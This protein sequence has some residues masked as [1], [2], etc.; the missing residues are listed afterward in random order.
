MNLQWFKGLSPEEK[1][2]AEKVLKNAKASFELLKRVLE[3]E[4]AQTEANA[5]KGEGYDSPSWALRQ[6]DYT[7]TKRTLQKLVKLIEPIT[8]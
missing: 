2:E 8:G 1:I 3:D 7:G 4:L 5:L 6:A